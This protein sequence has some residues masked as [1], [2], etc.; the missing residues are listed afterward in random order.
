MSLRACASRR[1]ICCILPWGIALRNTVQQACNF[2]NYFFIQLTDKQINAFKKLVNISVGR[3]A[4]ML[5]EMVDS[6]IFLEIPCIQI[7]NAAIWS[8]N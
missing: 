3:A 6:T 5:N 2:K 1:T 8:K 4:S 7:L